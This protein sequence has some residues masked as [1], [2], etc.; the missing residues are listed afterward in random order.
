[1]TF[2]A[3]MATEDRSEF[4]E[5]TR[6]FARE[7]FGARALELANTHDYPRGVF[8]ELARA[9]YFGLY[10]AEQLGGL[11][12]GLQTLCDVIESLAFVSNTVASMVIGQLQGSLP[13]LIAGDDELH[14]PLEGIVDK[15]LG[16]SPCELP[17]H[18]PGSPSVSTYSRRMIYPDSMEGGLCP[19]VTR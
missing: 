6:R 2:S 7:R 16:E 11:H 12:V 5:L 14:G 10:R 15:F 19:F 4:V 1:V 8:D 3:E 17:P 18:R 13:I 9:G